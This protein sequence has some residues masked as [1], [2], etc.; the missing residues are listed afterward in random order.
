[1]VAVP[2]TKLAI[3]AI[4]QDKDPSKDERLRHDMV[5]F[6]RQLNR[7]SKEWRFELAC[8]PTKAQYL[9]PR[10]L[11]MRVPHP[12]P[13]ASV[14]PHTR[15]VE[16]ALMAALC[17]AG[18]T[19]NFTAIDTG[20]I[21]F[22]GTLWASQAGGADAIPHFEGV[23]KRND[24]Y[25]ER[26]ALEV[27]LS[28]SMRGWV[29][30]WEPCPDHC[31]IYKY[32]MLAIGSSGGFSGSFYEPRSEGTVLKQRT[33]P[34]VAPLNKPYLMI[35]GMALGLSC[36]LGERCESTQGDISKMSLGAVTLFVASALFSV[37][38]QDR[39]KA[40]PRANKLL[41][42]GSEH[43][44]VEKR[45]PEGLCCNHLSVQPA[46]EISPVLCGIAQPRPRSGTF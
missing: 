12:A 33:K 25:I 32:E 34:P 40:K 26:P 41:K 7:T 30:I 39:Q 35:A 9:M 45:A 31:K 10:T 6:L 16:V 13:E 1:M 5:V 24:K 8:I 42:F 27:E 29:D 28:P 36:L 18:R 20:I 3:I 37:L 11:S 21:A 23:T 46:A 22:G 14:K 17:K 4:S 43:M 19:I 44:A 15:C 38:S 2:N